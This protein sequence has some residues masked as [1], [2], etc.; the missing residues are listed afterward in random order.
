MSRLANTTPFPNL[1]LDRVMPYVGDTEWRV[2]CAIVRQ[3]YGW[4]KEVDWLSHTQ[5]KRRTGRQSAAIS[6]AVD[7][8]VSRRIIQVMDSSGT[9]LDTR[10]LRRRS[11]SS[12]RYCVH[13]GLTALLLAEQRSNR[14]SESENNKSKEDK[15]KANN[16]VIHR[17]PTAEESPD[18]QD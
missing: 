4:Q 7:R 17:K 15:R 1:L 10:F 5:L 16:E 3:T 6:D 11:R 12:L 18:L 13:P 2:L 8:L 14:I 9:F